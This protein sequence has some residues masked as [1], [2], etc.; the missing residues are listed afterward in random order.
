MD[1]NQERTSPHRRGNSTKY[2][3]FGQFGAKASA[4]ISDLTIMKMESSPSEDKH[5][6]L[7]EKS[8]WGKKASA[9]SIQEKAEVKVGH[10]R[11]LQQNPSQHNSKEML[12][13]IK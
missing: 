11:C 8:L 7:K 10:A 6:K 4:Q 3:D 1:E 5:N 2:L 9:D 12:E 13:L